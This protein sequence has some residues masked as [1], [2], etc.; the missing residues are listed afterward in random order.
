MQDHYGTELQKGDRVEHADGTR[1][2]TISKLLNHTAL[3]CW[4]DNQTFCCRPSALVKI[5][6]VKGA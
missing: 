3:V 6:A 1:T 5:R 2:G 4:D